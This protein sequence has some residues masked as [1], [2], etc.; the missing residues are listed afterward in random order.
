VAKRT[1]NRRELRQQNDAAEARASD[2]EVEEVD[3]ADD[4]GDEESPKPKKAK[5]AKTPKVKAPAKPRVKKPR[6]KKAPPRRVAR[7]GVFDG[8]MKQLALFPYNQRAAADQKLVELA[9]KKAGTYFVQI[10]K[11]EMAEPEPAADAA[12]VPVGPA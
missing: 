7:W 6:A 2:A 11:E 9:A 8:A 10:V 3:D 1:L 12:G 4:D 5:A